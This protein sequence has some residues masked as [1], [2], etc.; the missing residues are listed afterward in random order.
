MEVSV[1][2]ETLQPSSAFILFI[3]K[4]TKLTFMT[5][6]QQLSEEIG[7]YQPLQQYI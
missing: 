3:L 7:H 6:H 2:I 5:T 1:Y 4:Y